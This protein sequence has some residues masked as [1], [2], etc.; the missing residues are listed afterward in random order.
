MDYLMD[1]KEKIAAIETFYQK[2]F[3]NSRKMAEVST[4]KSY[5]KKVRKLAVLGKRSEQE[6]NLLCQLVEHLRCA[7]KIMDDFID[8][9]EVR[10]YKPAFWVLHGTEA[11][12]EQAAWHLAQARMIASP[13]GI[14]TFEQRVCEV[15]AAARLEVEMENPKFTSKLSLSELWAEIVKKEASFR[16]LLVEALECPA[17]VCEA[18]YQDGV[19]GQTLDDGLSAIYGKDGRPDNSDERLGRLTYMRAFGVNPEEAVLCGREL[20][21]RIAPILGREEKG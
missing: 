8:E 6:V 12:I 20:K 18:A 15:I 10:D 7:F 14:A 11:T 16:L 21:K 3:E 2:S 13:L 1:Y 19:A 9:D 4:S 5:A 17:N